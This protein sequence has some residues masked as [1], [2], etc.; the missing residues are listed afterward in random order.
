[1][2]KEYIHQALQYIL[3][4]VLICG[5]LRLYKN[6]TKAVIDSNDHSMEPEYPYGNYSLDHSALRASEIEAGKIV[7]Y[8]LP[9]KSLEHR[10]AAVVATEGQRVSCANNKLLVNGVLSKVHPVWRVPLPE[11]VIP[12]GC[13]FLLSTVP[14]QDS[15]V[16][17]PIP[18]RNVIGTFK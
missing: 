16:F 13:L 18:M 12:K 1:M 4:I 6:S 17:G 11:L 14:D 3:T 7:A 9:G 8:Y 15:G 2:V 10:V 5:G